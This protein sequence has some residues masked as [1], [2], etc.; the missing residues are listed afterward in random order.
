MSLKQVLPCRFDNVIWN[1]L[2]SRDNPVQLL[3]ISQEYIFW[4]GLNFSAQDHRSAGIESLLL[5]RLRSFTCCA[6]GI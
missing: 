5:F 1:E 4:R 6:S 2:S 3:L